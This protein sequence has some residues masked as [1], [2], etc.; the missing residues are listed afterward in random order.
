MPPVTAPAVAPV[1]GSRA[2]RRICLIAF[3]PSFVL[4]LAH[5]IVSSKV[6]PALGLVPLAGSAL[7][8]GLLVRRDKAGAPVAGL[9]ALVVFVAD[10]V[11]ALMHLGMLIPTWITMTQD[12]W[13]AR[14]LIVLGTYC[15]LFLLLEL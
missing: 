9:L 5:G 1:A 6:V 11:L 13:Y 7:L 3:P 10:V 14:S 12:Y 8:G 15:T 2:L 4:F